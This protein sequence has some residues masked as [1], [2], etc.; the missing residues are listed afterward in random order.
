MKYVLKPAKETELN[1]IFALYASRVKWMDQVGIHQWNDTDYLGVY[2]LS[3]YKEH[4]QNCRLYVYKDEDGKIA[5]AAAL[6][7]KDGRW[8]DM[9]EVPAY[10]LHHLATDLSAERGIGSELLAQ[11]EKVAVEH[12]KRYMR[13]D[14]AVDNEFLKKY[15]GERGYTPAG[16]CIDGAYTG[17]R[18]EKELP[19][20]KRAW[21]NEYQG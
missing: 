17:L 14:C 18:L 6:L 13:L 19:L 16:Q 20:A 7:E 3:Y 12:G 4:Q 5:G 11:C 8:E 10:Y 2:P 15:Y 21:F 1:D 9:E